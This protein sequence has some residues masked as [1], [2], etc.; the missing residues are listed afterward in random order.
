MRKFSFST[1]EIWPVLLV[2]LG[3]NCC[4][5]GRERCLLSRKTPRLICKY[6][7]KNIFSDKYIT[8][9]SYSR[10]RVLTQVTPRVQAV[11]HFRTFKLQQDGSL[12]KGDLEES[13]IDDTRTMATGPFELLIGREFKLSVWEEMVKTM[14]V[15]EIARFICPFEVFVVI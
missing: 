10:A 14:R 13:V 3:R 8:V 11:L 4:T 7:A 5:Q 2:I 12:E 9:C 6:Y 1:E 15:G